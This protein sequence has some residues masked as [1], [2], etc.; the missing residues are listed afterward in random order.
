MCVLDRLWLDTTCTA[1][2]SWPLVL[3]TTFRATIKSTVAVAMARHR[4]L[5]R[6]GHHNRG[7]RR[8]C[9]RHVQRGRYYPYNGD[10]IIINNY[11]Y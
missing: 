6:S 9:E 5:E 1:L 8:G 10:N 11:K 3:W 7:R 4:L 2:R